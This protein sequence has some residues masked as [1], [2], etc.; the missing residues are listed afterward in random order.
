[1]L[2]R[3][4]IAVCSGIHAKHT[5]TH[6]HTHT[7]WAECRIS[8]RVRKTAKNYYQLRHVRLSVRQHGTTRLSHYIKT[9]VQLG[10][11]LAK[12]CSKRE[13]FQTKSVQKIKTHI[14]CSITFFP[15]KIVPF[16]R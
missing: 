5:H 4:I 2:Y 8:K 10:Q 1:M 9:Y 3:E 13:M 15:P 14:W 6:T 7:L 16:M 12:L 11:N